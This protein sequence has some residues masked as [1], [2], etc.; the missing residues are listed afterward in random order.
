VLGVDLLALTSLSEGLWAQDR[1]LGVG[2]AAISL[3]EIK[4]MDHL[5]AHPHPW[6]YICRK[7]LCLLH[8]KPKWRKGAA[9]RKMN[10]GFK[11]PIAQLWATF[12]WSKCKKKK[13]NV[14][15]SPWNHPSL[16]DGEKK[17]REKR[18][19]LFSASQSERTTGCSHITPNGSQD[20]DWEPMT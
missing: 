20:R 14:F 17:V 8:Q 4:L 9:P 5:R 11:R 2:D 18:V 15:F 6:M 1:C 16:E 19:E 12:V 3:W 7:S 13:K 10:T